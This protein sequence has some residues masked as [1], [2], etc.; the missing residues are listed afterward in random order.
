MQL[1]NVAQ[2]TSDQS[3]T[4]RQRGPFV[5]PKVGLQS[6][7]PPRLAARCEYPLV[8]LCDANS[9]PAVMRDCCSVEALET[10]KD[11]SPDDER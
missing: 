3:E 6:D 9:S 2:L 10:R 11:C 4:E 1:Y 8:V 7:G 5:A